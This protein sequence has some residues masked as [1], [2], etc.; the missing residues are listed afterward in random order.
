M[1]RGLFDPK[2]AAIWN[3]RKALWVMVHSRVEEDWGET[4]MAELSR[5]RAEQ[6]F[7][8]TTLHEYLKQNLSGF[9]RSDG[10][11]TVLQ[12][13][14]VFDKRACVSKGLQLADL[15]SGT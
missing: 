2:M 9:P 1:Q 12:F 15:N 3:T 4:K 7:D 14:F 10:S 13:R 6:K 5:V 8:E 11:L